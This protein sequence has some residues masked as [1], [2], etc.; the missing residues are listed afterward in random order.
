[1]GSA[2]LH[3]YTAWTRPGLHLLTTHERSAPRSTRSPAI[4]AEADDVL[5]NLITQEKM[6]AAKIKQCDIAAE[7]EDRGSEQVV[8]RGNYDTLNY[9]I[10]ARAPKVSRRGAARAL[11]SSPMEPAHRGLDGCAI[12]CVHSSVASMNRTLRLLKLKELKGAIEAVGTLVGKPCHFEGKTQG[13]RQ[14]SSRL[15]T[16]SK[17][18]SG[19]LG[20]GGGLYVRGAL[21]KRYN[22]MKDVASKKAK[23][24]PQ[25]Q[26]RRAVANAGDLACQIHEQIHVV[27]LELRYLQITDEK[28]ALK[29][30]SDGKF[31]L[32]N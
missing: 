28:A 9:H 22:A 12:D 3:E 30:L 10:K 14:M 19:L 18:R 5:L 6:R 7:D 13:E 4:E 11:T 20:G 29:E 16:S 17:R 32:Q 23:A 15:S 1:M 26:N 31:N 8:L 21:Q 27:R 24:R 2:A 25:A